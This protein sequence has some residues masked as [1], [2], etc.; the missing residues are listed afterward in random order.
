MASNWNRNASRAKAKVKMKTKKEGSV[1]AEEAA[2]QNTEL[3][4][5]IVVRG[6]TIVLVPI[7]FAIAFLASWPA[8]YSKWGTVGL[9][10][11]GLGITLIGSIL[12][13][14]CDRAIDDSEVDS[15]QT[16]N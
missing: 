9:L 11:N 6:V 12:Y 15:D 5:M 3:D 2:A 8:A 16:H 14:A 13:W 1:K 4:L 7:A 10:Y